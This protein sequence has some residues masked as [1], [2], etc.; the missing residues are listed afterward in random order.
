MRINAVTN[1]YG[2]NRVKAVLS[3]KEPETGGDGIPKLEIRRLK[4]GMSMIS[5]R[6]GNPRHIA[7]VVAEEPLFGMKDGGVGTVSH[8][9]NFLDR[10]VDKITKFIPLYN[11]EV[12][13][14]K[15]V[16]AT[17]GEVKGTLAQD[18]KVRYIPNDLPADHPFKG[19]EG[20]PFI[21]KQSIGV[22]DDLVKILKD[23]E[24]DI[25][26]LDEISSKKMDW[27]TEKEVPIKLFRARKDGALTNAMNKNQMS[28]ELQS[29]LD[30]IFVYVDSTA[31]MP[32]PYGD[33]SYATAAGDD[34]AKRFAS[35]WKGQEY[36]KF[37]KALVEQLPEFSQKTNIDPRYILCSDGQ[38][39]LTMH[40][41]AMKN[42]A[43]DPY[44]QDKFFG[45]VGHNMN[46]G[47][48]QEMG[49]RQA[50]VN[51]GATKE[52]IEK[53]VNSKKYIEALQLGEEEKFLRETVLKNFFDAKGGM[54]AYNIPI[55]Y[56]KAGYVPMLTTVSE[57]YHDS[58]ITN[59]L[60]SPL[61]EMLKELDTMGR[62]K[63]L[64]NVLMDPTV[65]GFTD[66]GLQAG[67]KLDT[68]LKLADGTEKTIKKFEIFD[69][70]KKYE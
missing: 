26:L 8:D 53:I 68:K 35:G 43:G 33:G 22:K 4:N 7:H 66:A 56:A 46:R 31:S 15:D 21:T 19:K 50:I 3:P 67:Y 38:S 41:A 34:L 55:H 44:F 64:T 65:S 58:I 62:F 48:I 9:Y 6:S 61:Y 63:G 17:T 59:E 54:S 45:G 60:V 47:Y 40:Y 25:L 18:V 36:A 52:D 57:G 32:K 37:N 10:N 13:Y 12:V 27:G 42:A 39:M 5:F 1:E 16:D 49:A 69:K 70:N 2:S 20:T 23:N 29:K 11:Q 14:K 51:L 24:N 28:K 30:F